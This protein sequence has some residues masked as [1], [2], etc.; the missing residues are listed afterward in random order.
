MALTGLD[1][2]TTLP[3]EMDSGMRFCETRD[4]DG[5]DV[6]PGT[7]VACTWDPNHAGVIGVWYTSRVFR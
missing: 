5:T 3:E 4:G 7:V 2:R 6:P 1:G